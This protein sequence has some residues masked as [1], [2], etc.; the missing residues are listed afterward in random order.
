[1]PTVVKLR[2]EM[3]RI[4]LSFTVKVSFLVLLD[5]LYNTR[6]FMGFLL[7]EAVANYSLYNSNSGFCPFELSGCKLIP[8]Y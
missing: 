2:V 4:S 1:M 8:F 3:R 7:K 5:T 6:K